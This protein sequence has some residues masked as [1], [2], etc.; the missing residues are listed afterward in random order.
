MGSSAFW[1]TEICMLQV[2]IVFVEI[3]PRRQS[4]VAFQLSN[5]LYTARQRINTE[6]KVVLR[7]VWDLM[8]YVVLD[9]DMWSN[10][11]ALWS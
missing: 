6:I 3:F 5:G 7:D 10:R 9:T 11:F 4:D 2:R 8:E 1:H